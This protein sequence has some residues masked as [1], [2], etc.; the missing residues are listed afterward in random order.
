MINSLHKTNRS[1]DIIERYCLVP[2]QGMSESELHYEAEPRRRKMLTT[3]IY[4]GNVIVAGGISLTSLFYHEGVDSFPGLTQ[5]GEPLYLTGSHWLAISFL[6]ILGLLFSKVKFSIV[7][8]HQLIYKFTYLA[9]SVVPSLIRGEI[10]EVPYG[11]AI[12]F[13]VWVVV[14]PVVIPWKYF[15]GLRLRRRETNSIAP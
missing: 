4:I 7:F 11:M 6:S 8:I 9:V 2:R 3:L 15:M 14:L 12:F 1:L 13:I 10:N 5:Y